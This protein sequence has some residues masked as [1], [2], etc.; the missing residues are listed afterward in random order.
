[1]IFLFHWLV[2]ITGWL[3][4]CLILRPKISYENKKIQSHR[5]KGRAIVVSNH[6]SVWDVATAMFTFPTR[7][8][9]CAVAELMYKKN[10][11]MSLFLR[12]LGTVKVDRTSHDFSFL[13]G[14][15]KILDRGGV[16]EIYPESRLPFKHEEIPLEFKPSAVYLALKTGAPIIPI[17]NNG[18]YFVKQRIRVHIGCPI[19]VRGLYRDELSEKENVANITAYVRGKII[20]FQKQL[21][22]QEKEDE[23]RR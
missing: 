15:G 20:E 2:K 9:R 11:L 6:R 1:M 16:V 19:D 12:L 4:Y 3:P 8:L 13:S 7:T 21:E 17:C 23:G 14:C 18:R 5:I 22:K 10:A